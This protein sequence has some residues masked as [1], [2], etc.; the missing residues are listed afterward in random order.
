MVCAMTL[1]ACKKDES[2]NTF[3][4]SAKVDGVA[5]SFDLSTDTVGIYDNDFG[6]I[7]LVSHGVLLVRA[8]N[9][10]KSLFFYNSLPSENYNGAGNY[11]I[12][13]GSE[14]SAGQSYTSTGT[15]N[16]SSDAN[17]IV[18]G[19]FRYDFADSLGNVTHVTE[20]KF[21]LPEIYP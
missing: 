17:G 14:V 21:R 12:Y 5:T 16:V 6:A 19:S 9:H 2:E 3:Y 20:G 15:L 10:T 1:F 7:K 8:Y 11:Y 13:G 18:V 4:L